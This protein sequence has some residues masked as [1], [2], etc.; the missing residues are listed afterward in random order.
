MSEE[1]N[2]VIAS[3]VG[4][5]I[6]SVRD[7]PDVLGAFIGRDGLLLTEGD[8]GPA[9]FDLKSGL[10]G[11]LLQ[12]FVNYRVRVA[13]VV[14]VPEVYGERFGELAYEHRS[15]PLIRFVPSRAEAET[16]LEF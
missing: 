13:I 9:F 15:H 8:L 4:I 7:I 3:E 12:K 5:A 14:P 16:W 2:V 10:A 1:R 6:H 11:E